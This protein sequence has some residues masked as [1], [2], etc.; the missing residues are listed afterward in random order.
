MITIRCLNLEGIGWDG[1]MSKAC[2]FCVEDDC[3]A[4]PSLSRKIIS[5]WNRV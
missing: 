4:I 3:D 2:H 1:L 5:E